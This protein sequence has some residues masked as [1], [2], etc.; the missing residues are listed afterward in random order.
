MPAFVQILAAWIGWI[1]AQ[2]RAFIVVIFA[3]MLALIVLK[4]IM[5]ILQLKFW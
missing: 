1:P 3:L 4:I 5:F 2:I